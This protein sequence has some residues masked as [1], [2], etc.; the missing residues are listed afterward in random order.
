MRFISMLSWVEEIGFALEGG[1]LS[2]GNLPRPLGRPIG[3]MALKRG[4]FDLSYFP[5]VSDEK[6]MRALG[7]MREGRSLN[8]A[9]YAFLS[10]FKI[11]ETAFPG[12]LKCDAWRTAAIS[13]LDRLGVMDALALLREQG[14]LTA[15]AISEHLYVSGRCAVAHAASTPVIDPDGP[16]DLYRLGSELPIMQA[17]AVRAIEDVFGVETRR[18]NARKHR[19]R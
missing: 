14:L 3:R 13:N 1:G 6:A 2:G 11:L 15:K 8:H 18:A 7:L 12:R 4:G 10:Y 17:L 5:E 16:N 9:G 19:N